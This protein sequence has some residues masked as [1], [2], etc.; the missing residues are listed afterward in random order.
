M[1]PLPGSTRHLAVNSR[2]IGDVN[3]EHIMTVTAVLRP[4]RDF[5]LAAHAAGGG[6][7]MS[8]EQFAEQHGADPDHMLKLEQYAATHHLS[9]DDVNLTKRTVV[10]RGRTT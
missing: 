9:V 3:P 2:F 5:S 7:T 1:K 8:R 6:G 4:K 10:L